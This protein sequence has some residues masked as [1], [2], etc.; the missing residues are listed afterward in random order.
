VTGVQTCA[1]PIYI[2]QPEFRITASMH[3]LHKTKKSY[4]ANKTVKS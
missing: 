3:R 4:D 1:L 2:A